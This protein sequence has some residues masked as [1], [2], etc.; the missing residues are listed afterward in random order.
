MENK[1]PGATEGTAIKLDD[2]G[3]SPFLV[4]VTI[5]SSGGPFL[6][7]Y[8]LGIIGVALVVLTPTLDIGPQASGLIGVASIV[9]IF[10]GALAGG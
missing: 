6:E 10:V 2:I 1:S 9:G 4:R 5:F 3:M 8:V 7:G